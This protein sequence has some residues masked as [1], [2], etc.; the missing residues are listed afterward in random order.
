MKKNLLKYSSGL[1]LTVLALVCMQS[2]STLYSNTPAT[3]VA[4]AAQRTAAT[5]F[6]KK[7]FNNNNRKTEY[8]T[9]ADLLKQLAVFDASFKEFPADKKINCKELFEHIKDYM[10]FFTPELQSFFETLSSSEFSIV[11]KEKLA[12][13]EFY[14]L[15]TGPINKVPQ[16]KDC[17]DQISKLLQGNQLYGQLREDL[18]SVRNKSGW[19]G[20]LSIARTLNKHINQLPKK[21]QSAIN[22]KSTSELS[23]R[24]KS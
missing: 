21:L 6:I 14:N 17:V 11:I 19:F 2:P 23:S 22:S 13:E 10:N 20:K 12:M 16:W 4:I 15:L 5:D 1:S 9:L 7:F 24:I 8:V 3:V 18:V